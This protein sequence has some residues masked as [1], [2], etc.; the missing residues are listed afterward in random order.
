MGLPGIVYA[1]IPFANRDLKSS[2]K[3]RFIFTEAEEEKT[4]LCALFYQIKKV[5]VV[6]KAESSG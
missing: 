6:L 4:I 2:S 3:M 1:K 5:I